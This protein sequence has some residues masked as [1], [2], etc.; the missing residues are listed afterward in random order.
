MTTIQILEENNFVENDDD[1]NVTVVV[2]EDVVTVQVL[3]GAGVEGPTGPLALTNS[4]TNPVGAPA[5]GGLVWWNMTDGRMYIS[6]Q[7]LGTDPAE[8]EWREA[9][10]GGTPP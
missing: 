10:I 9:Q 2:Q 3:D 4:T 7:I 5:S 8:Y 1:L 6:V